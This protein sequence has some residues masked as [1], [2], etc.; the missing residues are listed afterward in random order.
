MYYL[1]GNAGKVEESWSAILKEKI[2]LGSV[3]FSVLYLCAGTY[4]YTHLG[5]IL[6]TKS[7]MIDKKV[8]LK[9]TIN[10]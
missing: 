6:E 3:Q 9:S 7:E 4:I 5:L 1:F 8:D 10:S 2:K